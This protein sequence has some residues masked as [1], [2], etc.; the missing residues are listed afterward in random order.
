MRIFPAGI[1]KTAGSFIQEDSYVCEHCRKPLLVTDVTD[2][3]RHHFN[4]GQL[5]SCECGK[6]KIWANS[7]R[8]P[9][10][11]KDWCDGKPVNF[12]KDPEAWGFCNDE[13]CPTCWSYWKCLKNGYLFAG[14]YRDLFGCEKCGNTAVL[15]IGRVPE[16]TGQKSLAKWY[17]D[18][19]NLWR[20]KV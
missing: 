13:Y 9:E 2:N 5:L 6:S 12:A 3:P 20:S 10:E 7:V 18:H 19:Q 4:P 8:Y 14:R 16:S 1:T 17:K 15:L 11:L